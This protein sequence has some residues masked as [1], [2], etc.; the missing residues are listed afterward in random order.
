MEKVEKLTGL[1]GFLNLLTLG[2][3]EE[4]TRTQNKSIWSW[5]NYLSQLLSQSIESDC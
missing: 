3:Y 1:R 4:C 5:K 2:L